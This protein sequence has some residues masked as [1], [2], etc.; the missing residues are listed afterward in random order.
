MN[1]SLLIRQTHRW[2]GIALVVLTLINIAAFAMGYAIEWLYYLPLLPL[3][4]LMISGVYL[5]AQPYLGRVR[6]GGHA[7]S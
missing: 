1:W 5:F 3:F 2:L 6:N 7:P 4:L